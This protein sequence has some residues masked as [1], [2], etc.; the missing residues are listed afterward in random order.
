MD[1]DTN[2]SFSDSSNSSSSLQAVALEQHTSG[3]R[4]R[5]T[6][7]SAIS[8]EALNTLNM[9]LDR[10]EAQYLLHHPKSLVG[11]A[12]RSMV[13]GSLLGACIVSSMYV[14]LVVQ[15]PIWRLPLYVALLALFHF[16]EYYSTARYNVRHAT[17]SAFLLTSNGNAYYVAH[18]S[19][20]AECLL[21][22]YWY[23]TGMQMLPPWMAVSMLWLGIGM[24]L[25]GQWI[26]T[27]AMRDAGTNFNHIVQHTKAPSHRLV[28]NGVYSVLRHPSYFGFFWWSLGTQMLLGNMVCMVG[29]AIA[30]WRFFDSR[31]AA[32]EEALERFFGNDYRQYRQRVAVGIPLIR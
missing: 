31:I 10:N 16:L 28:T 11:V 15:R 7:S 14:L 6:S 19:A 13:L 29:F 21:R 25:A 23:P 27:R 1:T 9:A 26:R 22:N 12:C 20:V 24:V 8:P 3:T 18:L 17:T 30:L 32:E 2:D 5:F 4:S